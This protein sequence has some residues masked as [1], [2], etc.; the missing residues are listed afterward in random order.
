M[1]EWRIRLTPVF[2]VDSFGHFLSLPIHGIP[3]MNGILIELLTWDGNS[4]R[5]VT[6][7]TKD[8][9]VGTPEPFSFKQTQVIRGG[10]WFE[11]D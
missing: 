5:L 9:G 1:N 4:Q 6:L 10:R 3:F 8:F 7:T 2:L 11:F